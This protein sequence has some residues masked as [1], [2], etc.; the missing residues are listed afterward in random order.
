M[1]SR[2]KGDRELT[3][4]TVETTIF[5]FVTLKSCDDSGKSSSKRQRCRQMLES[6][7]KRGRLASICKYR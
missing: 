4:Y 5:R 1:K 6:R 3:G 7:D 2:T